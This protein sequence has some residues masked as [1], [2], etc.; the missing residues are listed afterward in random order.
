MSD[1][2]GAVMNR[3]ILNPGESVMFR[4]PGCG[5]KH[6]LNINPDTRPCWSFNG[7]LERPTLSPSINAWREY[8]GNRKTQ[9]CHSFV[10]N[11]SIRFLSDCTH[12]FAN[13]TVPLPPIEAET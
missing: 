3:V 9:R 5:W 8:G 10:E 13:Q 1:Q 6:T 7:D 4:C 11:G 2:G 12:A